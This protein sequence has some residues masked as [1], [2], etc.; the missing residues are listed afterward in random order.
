MTNTKLQRCYDY[1]KIP[2]HQM[3]IME[4][5]TWSEAGLKAMIYAILHPN[6][7][8]QSGQAIFPAPTLPPGEPNFSQILGAL[9]IGSQEMFQK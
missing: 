8:F 9:K 3:K 1:N 2:E 4:E 7:S 6:Q 5:Q